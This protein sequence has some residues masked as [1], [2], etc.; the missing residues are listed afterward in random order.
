MPDITGYKL[1]TK[2]K[3]ALIG[4]AKTAGKAAATAVP[5]YIYTGGNIPATAAAGLAGATMLPDPEQIA[6]AISSGVQAVQNAFGAGASN[7]QDNQELARFSPE[8]Q[9]LLM[10]HFQQSALG[11]GTQGFDPI[12]DRYRRMFQ[13]QTIPSIAERFT[14]M[15]QG[16]QRG[17]S[18]P[19]A[20]GRAGS[21]L[22]SQLAAL[23]AQYGQQQEVFDTN[24]MLGLL[25]ALEKN[26]LVN[27][28]GFGES[29]G[30]SVLR[31]GVSG[32]GDLAKMYF[33]NR[34]IGPQSNQGFGNTGNILGGKGV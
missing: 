8:V 16:A 7:P 20:L 26:Y 17:S 33:A 32:L 27:R 22:E 1:G 13:E 3:N 6:P 9:Q 25:P 12:E 23:R 4:G 30:Q 28:P 10:Q 14:A 31:G 34:L 5:T 18:F 15:G 2:L 11:S 19:A 24:K 21:D 29:L